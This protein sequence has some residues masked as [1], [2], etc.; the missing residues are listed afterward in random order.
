MDREVKICNSIS[1]LHGKPGYAEET[2]F[3][4]DEGL[5]MDGSF[6][7]GPEEMAKSAV[8]GFFSIY[9]YG[10]VDYQSCPN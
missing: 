1:G 2:I 6:T 4:N 7:I 10:C 5:A 9:V 8:V 3:P